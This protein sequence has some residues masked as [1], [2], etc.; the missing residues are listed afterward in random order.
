MPFGAVKL[1]A[2][3]IVVGIFAGTALIAACKASQVLTITVN[4]TVNDRA[5][6]FAPDTVTV[7]VCVPAVSPAF[8]LTVKLLVVFPAGMLVSEVVFS[9]KLLA[10]A[11]DNATVR[12][13]V[14]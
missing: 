12:F 5:V 6:M 9:V 3:S 2:T 13:P 4:V 10:F 1:A 11:P 14:G 8:G 7:A